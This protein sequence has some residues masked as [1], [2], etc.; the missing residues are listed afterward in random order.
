MCVCLSWVSVCVSNL[1]VSTHC[2]SSYCLLSSMWLHWYFHL[3]KKREIQHHWLQIWFCWSISFRCPEI[4]LC[5]QCTPHH[6]LFQ[7]HHAYG[8]SGGCVLYVF[9]VETTLAEQEH[10]VSYHFNTSTDNRHLALLLLWLTVSWQ[11]RVWGG[12]RWRFNQ[13]LKRFHM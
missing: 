10:D 8:C 4:V 1:S 7:T 12:G 9:P 3:L 11:G 13:N 6:T 5:K 2:S